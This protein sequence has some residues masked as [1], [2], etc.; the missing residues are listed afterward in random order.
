M[1][2]LTF[3]RHGQASFG[4][5]NYDRLT[6]LGIAQAAQTGKYFALRPAGFSRILTGPL[7]RQRQTA[8]RILE[9]LDASHAVQIVPLLAEFAEPEQILAAAAR[10]HGID[11]TAIGDLPHAEQLRRY[12]RAITAWAN[13]TVSLESAPSCAGFVEAVGNWFD[14]AVS[15]T[16]GAQR[17]LAVTSAGVI[18][19]C[20][21]RHFGLPVGRLADLTAVLGNCSVTEFVFS[22]GRCSL[23][24]F[25]STSHLEDG[26]ISGI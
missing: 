10:E 20:M 26:L 1:A 16:R 4:T 21:I 3:V 23:L 24:R 11:T 6:A 22:T 14:E 9:Q 12:G 17:I 2:T 13:G 8:D 25:N 15:G 19:A 5:G 18:A 7:Q